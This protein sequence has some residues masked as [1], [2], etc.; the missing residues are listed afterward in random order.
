MQVADIDSTD[1]CNQ[2]WQFY[3]ALAFLS[4]IGHTGGM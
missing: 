1:F 3:V 4:V 2:W